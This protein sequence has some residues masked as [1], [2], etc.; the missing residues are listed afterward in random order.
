MP[1]LEQGHHHELTEVLEGP[2]SHG[3]CPFLSRLVGG[4]HPAYP[5]TCLPQATKSKSSKIDS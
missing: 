2:Q 1:Q 4:A 3:Q 5:T